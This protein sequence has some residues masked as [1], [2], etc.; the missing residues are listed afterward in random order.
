MS[1]RL[2]RCHIIS[3]HRILF[4]LLVLTPDCDSVDMNGNWND[5]FLGWP[6]ILMI[7]QIGR[8]HIVV[9]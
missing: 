2:N 1:Y 5:Q 7:R 3:A 4:H 6:L 8:I 9:G